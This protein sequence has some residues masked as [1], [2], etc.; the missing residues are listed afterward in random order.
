MLLAP[1]HGY[2]SI[3]QNLKIV[4]DSLQFDISDTKLQHQEKE[5]KIQLNT[6]LTHEEDQ[7]GKKAWKI[8]FC[9]VIEIETSY[10]RLPRSDKIEIISSI[11]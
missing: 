5:L 10:T 1:S 7:T 6:W 11:S 9:W 2:F 4:Q 3:R 8:G